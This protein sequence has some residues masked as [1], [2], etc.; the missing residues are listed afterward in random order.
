MRFERTREKN[1]PEKTPVGK[2]C[3]GNLGKNQGSS[4]KR[5]EAHPTKALQKGNLNSR[6]YQTGSMVPRKERTKQRKN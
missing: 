5:I 6:S 4:S 1:L 3:A 2:I